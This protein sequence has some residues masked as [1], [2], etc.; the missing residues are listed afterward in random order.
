MIDSY[1]NHFDWRDHG[2]VTKVKSQRKF[3]YFKLQILAINT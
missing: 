2:V 1:P 3:I